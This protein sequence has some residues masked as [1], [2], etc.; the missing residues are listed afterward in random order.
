MGTFFC[1]CCCCCIEHVVRTRGAFFSFLLS[2][3]VLFFFYIV[4]WDVKALQAYGRERS[5]SGAVLSVA[6]GRSREGLILTTIASPEN[7]RFSFDERFM[8]ARHKAGYY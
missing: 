5:F 4:G 2:S 1:C 6:R 8:A 7:Q 3:L